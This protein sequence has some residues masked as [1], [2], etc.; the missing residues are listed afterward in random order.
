MMY[1]AKTSELLTPHAIGTWQ[2]ASRER[3]KEGN[4]KDDGGSCVHGYYELSLPWKEVFEVVLFAA[5]E[6]QRK[7]N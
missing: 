2:K 7:V 1:S 6:L 5:I 3:W 4:T